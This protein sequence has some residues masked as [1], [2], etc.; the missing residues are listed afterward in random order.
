M[1]SKQKRVIKIHG[2]QK[3]LLPPKKKEENLKN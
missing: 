3:L 2:I 1:N